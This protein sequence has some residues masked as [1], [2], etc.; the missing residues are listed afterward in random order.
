VAFI[1]SDAFDFCDSFLFLFYFF[2]DFVTGCLRIRLG[3]N[4]IYLL[5]FRPI[6]YVVKVFG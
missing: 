4:L 2:K 6:M 5:E 3:L 1:Q